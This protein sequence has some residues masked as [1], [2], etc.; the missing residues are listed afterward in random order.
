MRKL[1]CL[2]LAV[3]VAACAEKKT[4]LPANLLSHNDFE[5]L[6]GWMGSNE[7]LASLTT[8]QAHSGK[9]SAKVDPAVEFSAGYSK[10]LGKVADHM[11][12]KLKIQAWVNIANSK[13]APFIVTE[14]K[15]AGTN[16][17]LLWEGIE[18]A[19]EVKHYNM[20]VQV[21]KTVSMPAEAA[22]NDVLKVYLWRGN[23]I[24]PTYVDDMMILNEQ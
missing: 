10:P 11:P 14:L 23:S 6:D 3:G 20:W 19:K 13:A 1:L 9:Y 2:L 16:K 12:K 17:Q 7:Y 8:E 5:E 21:E 18:L 15:Q 22:Y 24:Q 4:E